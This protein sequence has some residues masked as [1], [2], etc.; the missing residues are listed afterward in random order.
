MEVS[1]PAPADDSAATPSGHGDIVDDAFD[2]LSG[3]QEDGTLGMAAG[4]A[5]NVAAPGTGGLASAAVD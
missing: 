4:I 5:A 2:A 1:V 3:A